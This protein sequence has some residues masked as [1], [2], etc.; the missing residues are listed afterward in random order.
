MSDV[1]NRPTV[2]I[3]AVATPHAKRGSKRHLA[4][5]EVDSA[6][7]RDTGIELTS[8]AVSTPARTITT[9][10][11][12]HQTR[13]VKRAKVLQQAPQAN[14]SSPVHVPPQWQTI[15]H[16]LRSY[17]LTRPVCVLTQSG[18]FS[19]TLHEVTTEDIALASV[20]GDL[21]RLP[22]SAILSVG[23]LA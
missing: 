3:G 8:S 20:D 7:S 15:S 2:F 13:T 4:S 17:F 18:R 14:A 21:H 1:F 22:F 23:H 12:R 9:P 16:Y 10:V 6:G 11:M 19:G 5:K